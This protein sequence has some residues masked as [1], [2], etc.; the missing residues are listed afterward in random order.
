MQFDQ[1][2][3][4][5]LQTAKILAIKGIY[6]PSDTDS[7]CH[8]ASL[9]EILTNEVTIKFSSDLLCFVQFNHTVADAQPLRT[10][11]ENIPF[12]QSREVILELKVVID[13]LIFK[14]TIHLKLLN[15]QYWFGIENRL[16]MTFKITEYQRDLIPDFNHQ[17]SSTHS[18]FNQFNSML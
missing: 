11:L 5:M 16:L 4:E 17:I 15:K 12:R 8:V 18:L 1:A 7:P 9:E 10:L 14:I 13:E 2:E 6:Y 3:L